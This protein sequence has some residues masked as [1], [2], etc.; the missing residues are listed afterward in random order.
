MN[1]N[2]TTFT[3][4]VAITALLGLGLYA[5]LYLADEGPSPTSSGAKAPAQDQAAQNTGRTAK[6]PPSGAT[7][8]PGSKS[9]TGVAGSASGTGSSI[10]D[11]RR[12][13]SAAQE[14]EEA[15]NASE[16]VH[17]SKEY[18][19]EM[20]QRE[21]EF[22]LQL[23]DPQDRRRA[24]VDL[25]RLI[26]PD[27]LDLAFDMLAQ[28]EDP[29]EQITFGASVINA[30]LTTDPEAAANWA[31]QAP[32]NIKAAS[33]SKIAQAWAQR[34]ITAAI[35][36]S[37]Q[38][39][40]PRLKY[41]ALDEITQVWATKDMNATY[42]WAVSLK[43][44][45]AQK[46]VFNKMGITLARQDPT[47]AAQWA[48]DFEDNAT[49]YSILNYAITQWAKKD[50][51]ATI[52]WTETLPEGPNKELSTK[53][54][55]ENWAQKDPVAAITWTASLP[56]GNTRTAAVSSAV[57]FWSKKD[58]LPAFQWA[59]SLSETDPVKSRALH[60]VVR[61]WAQKNTKEASSWVATISNPKLR[62]DMEKVVEQIIERQQAT[63][64]TKRK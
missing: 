54:I 25:A 11:N 61:T 38:I 64:K 20:L 49:R 46:R 62:S 39:A 50:L 23:E 48:L 32:D 22:A 3:I 52:A 31:E 57:F 28:L 2:K 16:P 19:P 29:S 55:I 21:L 17:F 40:D 44:P 27:H 4:T 5:A 56:A 18:N 60:T 13:D 45:E 42:D 24:L 43:D 9:R 12:P 7:L 63:Q 35:E 10:L 34:D 6:R 33:Y 14:G 47:A 58:P 37:Q 36:W 41:S 15:E 8:P 53:K 26:A 30:M 51:G 59:S 1:I